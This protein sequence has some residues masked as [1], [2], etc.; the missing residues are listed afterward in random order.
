MMKLW[1]VVAVL[2]LVLPAAAWAEVDSAK[3]GSSIEEFKSVVAA[4]GGDPHVVA[5]LAVLALVVY[6]RD[7]DLARTMFSLLV[8]PDDVTP[9]GKSPTGYTV[10][11][12]VADDLARTRGKENIARGYCG[13]TPGKRYEDADT[14][15]CTVTFDT[16]YSSTRQGVNFP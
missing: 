7:E 6:Q 2:G 11:R 8:E 16:Q 9:D 1:M 13:G 12:H 15:N 4:Q 14:T 3:V 10:V 5:E